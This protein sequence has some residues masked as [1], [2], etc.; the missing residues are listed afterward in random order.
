[1][2]FVSL[3]ENEN[4]IIILDNIFFQSDFIQIVNMIIDCHFACLH[5]RSSLL[6]MLVKIRNYLDASFK[7]FVI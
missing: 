1:M 5:F 4:E 3:T 6:Y 7:T 2:N